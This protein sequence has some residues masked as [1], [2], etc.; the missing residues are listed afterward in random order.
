[1]TKLERL[2]AKARHINILLE[3]EYTELFY[4]AIRAKGITVGDKVRNPQNK[5][6]IITDLTF[7]RERIQIDTCSIKKDGTPSKN[8]GGI[9]DKYEEL[10]LVESI[11]IPGSYVQTE[12]YPN[13]RRVISHKGNCWVFSN[14]EAV[15]KE[16]CE[17]VMPPALQETTNDYHYRGDVIAK[18]V[19]Y[20]DGRRVT[21]YPVGAFTEEYLNSLSDEELR[22]KFYDK[23]TLLKTFYLPFYD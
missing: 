5:M 8:S 4:K 22:H 17:K 16:A 23:G 12:Y 21:R 13:I 18:I 6:A 10:E 3:E 19:R 7:V 14:G 15:A 9:Y 2:K 1:M 11:I 20:I